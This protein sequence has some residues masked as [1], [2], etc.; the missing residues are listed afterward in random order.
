MLHILLEKFKQLSVATYQPYLAFLTVSSRSRCTESRSHDLKRHQLFL[1]GATPDF[2]C[3]GGK[4]LATENLATP[5]S[6][7]LPP[8][9][10]GS[11]L[12]KQELGRGPAA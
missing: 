12:M 4:L 9:T 2:F 6:P 11:I 7:P 5:P 1:S 10:V 8:A 3:V